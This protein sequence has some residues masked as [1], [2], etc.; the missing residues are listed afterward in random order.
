MHFVWQAKAVVRD[1]VLEMRS[2]R[3]MQVLLPTGQLKST[4][5]SL[6]QELSVLR[7][8]RSDQAAGPSHCIF[9]VQDNLPEIAH[10]SLCP[11]MAM[12]ADFMT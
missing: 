9:K 7:I 5:L 4:T 10:K 6:N 1:F 2:G 12:H 8:V 11:D 3:R